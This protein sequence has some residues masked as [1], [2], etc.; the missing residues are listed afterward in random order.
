MNSF[1]KK[2][3]EF[4]AKINDLV[5]NKDITTKDSLFEVLDHIQLK[6]GYHLGLRLAEQKGMGDHSWFYTFKDE[7][8]LKKEKTADIETLK[9]KQNIFNDLIVKQTEM[10]A[11]QA[12]LLSLDSTVLP[13]WWHANYMGR[14]FFFD[15]DNFRG[16]KPFL[17]EPLPLKIQD[18]PQPSVI[19]KD[20]HFIVRCPYWNDWE[21]LVLVSLN[22]SFKENGNVS[23]DNFHQKVLYEFYSGIHF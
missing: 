14:L 10:G 1:E 21:G 3:V 8:P 17:S 22:V 6:D 7:D 13:L 9:E 18:I 11:W 5:C 12:Y 19:K 23:F 16:I 2:G 15:R 4:L 20:D